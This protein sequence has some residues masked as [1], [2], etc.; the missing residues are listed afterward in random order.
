IL[1]ELLTGR[2]PFKGAT[3]V[4]IMAQV[5]SEEP[6]APRKLQPQVPRDLE[7][8]CLK[9]LRKEPRQRYASAEGL[10]DDVQRFLEGK[11]IVA[12][13]ASPG[14]RVWKWARR[15]PAAAALVLVSLAAAFG[16]V[17]GGLLFAEQESR[18]ADEA[19]ALHREAEAQKRLALEN[20]R[21]A[22]KGE[23]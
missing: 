9:C 12:R 17:V 20:E 4:Q 14:E 21:R 1:Y 23:E 7:T 5:L 10:A 6:V 22:R 19:E 2:P 15:K 11:P 3:P 16:L 18:R 13:P 8:I